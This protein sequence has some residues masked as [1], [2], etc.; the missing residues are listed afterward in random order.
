LWSVWPGTGDFVQLSQRTHAAAIFPVVSVRIC[1]LGFNPAGLPGDFDDASSYGRLVGLSDPAAA[2][3]WYEDVAGDGDFI[4]PGAAGTIP[5]LFVGS[6]CCRRGRSAYPVQA[7][8]PESRIFHIAR[9]DLLRDLGGI[10]LR[11]EQMVA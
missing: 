5:A 1:L 7:P 2:G 11:A 4:Y 6:A 8:I 10:G 3:S 9:R